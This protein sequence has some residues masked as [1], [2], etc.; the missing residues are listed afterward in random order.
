[1]RSSIWDFA[2]RRPVVFTAFVCGI[3]TAFIITVDKIIY[4]IDNATDSNND[5]ENENGV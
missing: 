3:T 5:K 1:M 4:A 2:I